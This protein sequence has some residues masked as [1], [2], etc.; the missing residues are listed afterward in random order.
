M[1]MTALALGERVEAEGTP[2]DSEARLRAL[3]EITTDILWEVDQG[4]AYT[5]CSSNLARVTGHRPEVT[6]GKTPV[7]FM[8]PADARRFGQLLGAALAGC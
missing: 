6:N 8:L 3:L 2:Q 1:A 7:D 4:G 5:Y